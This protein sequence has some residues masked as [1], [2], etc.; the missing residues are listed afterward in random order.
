[1]ERGTERESPDIATE[2]GLE[3]SV[4]GRHSEKRRKVACMVAVIKPTFKEE[5]ALMGAGYSRIAGTDEV[6]AGCLAGPVFAAAVILPIDSRIPLIRDSKLLSEKQRREVVGRIKAKA[7]AWAV[8]MASVE[9]IDTI[10]IRQAGALAMRRAVESLKIA[11]DFILVDG[12]EIQGFP[13]PQKRIVK[14]DRFVKTIAAAS[15][16]AKVARDRLMAR[17]ED[18]F[19][20]YGFA[21]HK[22]YGTKTHQEALRRLGPC[23]IHRRSYGPVRVLIDSMTI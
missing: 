17:Y 23:P 18:E 3:V 6:G 15:I 21:Q 13:C 2:G 4:T 19:P 7:A 1:M 22:G 14:G 16:I 20:G 11:P 5:R 9:E 10:N 12:F 8:G